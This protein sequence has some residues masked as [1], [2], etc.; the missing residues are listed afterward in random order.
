MSTKSGHQQ[1][2]KILL[3]QDNPSGTLVFSM[4]C[5]PR[6]VLERDSVSEAYTGCRNQNTR[7]LTRGMNLRLLSAGTFTFA[8]A[9][10]HS[11]QICSNGFLAGT[12]FSKSQ[13]LHPR[14]S[15]LTNNADL[16]VQKRHNK[17]AFL[18]IPDYALE[19]F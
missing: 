12:S 18:F 10:F 7:G 6:Q 2:T 15:R 17:A 13:R 14:I 1:P 19:D 3:V 5:L 11:F 8:A 9:G 16:L 4:K